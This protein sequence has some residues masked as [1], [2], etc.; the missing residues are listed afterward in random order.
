MKRIYV[1]MAAAV[2]IAV[3]VPA[4][5]K[6]VHTEVAIA[7][8]VMAKTEWPNNGIAQRELGNDSGFMWTMFVEERDGRRVVWVVRNT[9]KGKGEAMDFFSGK[10]IEV[11][12]GESEGTHA[13]EAFVD[14]DG[15]RHESGDGPDFGWGPEGR[16]GARRANINFRSGGLGDQPI[17]DD[18]YSL[19]TYDREPDW[20]SGDYVWTKIPF[21]RSAHG[22]WNTCLLPALDLQDGTI[23][24][25]SE[26]YVFRLNASDFLPF[27][28][29]PALHIRDLAEVKPVLDEARRRQVTDLDTFL[30]TEL[31]LDESDATHRAHTAKKASHLRDAD[32][33]HL[34]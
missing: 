20:G 33:R 29:A 24:V 14:M 23:L 21:F 27:G 31:H 17:D 8:K 3:S 15:V 28:S 26:K 30:T 7:K 4:R 22:H 1:A 16:Y 13:V 6:E 18:K 34:D 32:S 2:V 19:D 9:V 5:T 10:V 12:T 25:T 11:V